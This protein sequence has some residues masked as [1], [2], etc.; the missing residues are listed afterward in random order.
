MELN[1]KMQMSRAVVFTVFLLPW[2][3]WFKPRMMIWRVFGFIWVIEVFRLFKM[4][5]RSLRET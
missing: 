3:R 1:T 4:P 5:E 2:M